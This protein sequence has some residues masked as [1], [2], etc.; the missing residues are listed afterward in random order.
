MNSFIKAMFFVLTVRQHTVKT[1]LSSCYFSFIIWNILIHRI[2][3]SARINPYIYGR[4][5][6]CISVSM[7][8][9]NLDMLSMVMILY[10][11]NPDNT[12]IIIFSVGYFI[13]IPLR[14]RCF[15]FELHFPFLK[16]SPLLLLTVV[17]IRPFICG[18]CY[19]WGYLNI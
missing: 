1:L 5:S 10:K 4:E 8:S 18:N 11:Q 19:L 17:Y 7:F 9:G 6:I 13:Y 15:K 16:N 3:M 2:M 12:A 14:L